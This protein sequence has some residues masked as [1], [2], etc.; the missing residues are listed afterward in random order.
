MVLLFFCLVI[1]IPSR[2]CYVCAMKDTDTYKQIIAEL[3]QF[4]AT[5][6]A[7]YNESVEQLGHELALKR[8]VRILADQEPFQDL[9]HAYRVEYGNRMIN[10]ILDEIAFFTYALNHL[11]RK[12]W[13]DDQR[14]M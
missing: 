2:A 1:D 5:L 10:G 12:T 11:N 4:Y 9:T 7:T 6:L 3:S 14:S 13:Q 8:A